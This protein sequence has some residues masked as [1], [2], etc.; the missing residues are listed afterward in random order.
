MSFDRTNLAY[1]PKDIGIEGDVVATSVEKSTIET[2]A[3]MD[4]LLMHARVVKEW[5]DRIDAIQYLQ[6]N[7]AKL[8]GNPTFIATEQDI[9]RAVE[10]M[11]GKNGTIDFALFQT[12]T[13][14]VLE[15]YRQMALVAITGAA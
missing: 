13:E 11:G 5:R 1:K 7:A 9:A 2:E 10:V 15:G 6:D 14:N 12:C 4:K 3:A 8:A